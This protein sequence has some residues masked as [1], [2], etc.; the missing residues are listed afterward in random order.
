M[1][2]SR[3]SEE[4]IVGVWKEEEAGVPMKD[5]CRR[6]GISTA[7]FYHW[8]A[9][10]GGLEVSETRR[11]RQ[12]EEEKR[13]SEEDRGAAGAGPGRTE[14]GVSK[15]VVGPQ[16]KREAVRVVR[17]EAGLSERRACGL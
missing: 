1:K 9:K 14:G 6:I 13:A 8:K 10:Y 5:L 2:G 12:L 11:L 4:Q 16:A 15:K 7:T 3:F 17:E